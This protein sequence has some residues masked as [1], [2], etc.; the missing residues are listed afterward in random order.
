MKIVSRRKHVV[1]RVQLIAAAMMLVATTIT[2]N[3]MLPVEKV[4]AAPLN[5]FS[6]SSSSYAP[7][8]TATYT[9]NYMT[10]DNSNLVWRVQGWSQVNFSQ[11]TAQVTINGT[12]HNP[13]VG[14][15]GYWNGAHPYIR[16]GNI[17]YTVPSG[18]HVQ[19]VLTGVINPSSPGTY[20]ANGF[21]TS[22][23][24]NVFVDTSPLS[25]TIVA[26]PVPLDF[27]TLTN[28]SVLVEDTLSI[29]D[30]ALTGGTGSDIVNVNL[31]VPSGSLAFDS[32]TGLTFTGSATGNNL[33]FSGTKSAINAALATLQYTAGDTP[34]TFKLEA[35][36][37]EAGGGVIW[38]ENGHAYKVVSNPLSWSAAKTAAEAQTFGGVPGYL[39]T[40]TSEDEHN[41]VL[42]RIDQ[43]GWIGASDAGDEGNWTWRTG[44]E[45]GMQF[46]SG[47]G[48]TGSAVDD[49][50]SNWSLNE[51]NDAGGNEDCAQIRFTESIHG[52]WNDL[53]CAAANPNYVVEF[54]TPENLPQVVSASF[55]ITVVPH[56]YT[57]TFD[58]DD[59]TTIAPITGV[60]EG[61]TVTLPATPQRA[62]YIFD[63]WVEDSEANN[64]FPASG[65][66]VMP[67]HDVRFVAQWKED[68]NIDEVLD[69]EQENVISLTDPTT[70]KRVTLEIDK[71]CT[72]ANA[73]MLRASDLTVKDSAY[74]YATDFV[75]FT[76]TGCDNDK[77]TV[78]L[79]YYG[80]SPD[81]LT[82]RK[83]NPNKN[84]YFT[85]NDALL[86]KRTIVG[87]NVTVVSY[88]V[89][90]GG[91]LD[92]DG[93][94]NGTITDPVGL[95][96]LAVEVPRTGLGGKNK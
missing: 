8:A 62:G 63:G 20:T 31:F 35:L 54:G 89:T 52:L 11:S 83:H 61:Q 7:G 57:L 48:V 34:G 38:S 6:F 66:F 41:F 37:N 92:I 77:T 53:D 1:Q 75:N 15:M 93:L 87:Q 27:T 17:G 42:Q 51:P 73:T 10:I 69:E 21:G 19:V 39:A 2:G 23:D 56:T 65:S 13:A 46:W 86:T 12:V 59:G 45:T 58:T 44:P 94:K 5:G 84:S 3:I 26:P 33:Q 67:D 32:S 76:A 64:E 4:L 49:E 47:N 79:Y 80:T 81:G 30:L 16:L 36:I 9:F 82:V 18:A 88:E 70:N 78:N 60:E 29:T 25:I 95:G 22:T 28:K 85:I 96:K 74:K 91:E 68:G 55:N 14:G 43:S 24:Q 90:D 40:I 71:S 50:F 72:M